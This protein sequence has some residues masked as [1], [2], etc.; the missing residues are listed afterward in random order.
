VTTRRA[1]I[2]TLAGGLLAAP[3]AAEAQPAASLPRI[4]FLAPTSLSDPRVPRYLQAFR[5]GLRELGYI[6]GQSIAIEFRWAEL[7]YDRLPSL[8]AELVRLKVNVIVAAGPP[9]IQAAKQA[10]ETIPIVMAAVAD[11]V[12]AGFVASLARPG[13][14][15]TGLSLMHSE[16]VGKQLE[17]LKEVLPKVSRVALLG[18]PANPNYAPLLRHAQDAARALGVRLQ[19]LEARN[20]SEID[21]ALAAIT[22][23]RTGALIV[24]ADTV[25][26]DHR[27]RIADYAIRRRLPTVFGFSEFAEV[28]GL[29]AYGPSL[30]DGFRRTATYVDKILKGAKPADLPIGQPTKFEFVV[31][32]KTAKAIG[33]TIPSSLLLRADEVIQ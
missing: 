2:G 3:L 10:T 23:E 1:F 21:S 17:L 14:N 16:L 33:L 13:G 4:G 30:S 32:L 19:P 6:E 26:L 18:N 20:S 27:T 8:A 25:L 9:A 24:L 28:G 5:Q 12:A 7:Q 29:L 11:A 22:R 15:I 31:N